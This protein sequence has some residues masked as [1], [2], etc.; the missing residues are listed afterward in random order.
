MSRHPDIRERQSATAV[1]H[2]SNG[3]PWNITPLNTQVDDAETGFSV[4]QARC[5]CV[6]VRRELPVARGELAV[7]R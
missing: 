7:R 6:V 2:Y 1:M 4:K 3:G 5:V